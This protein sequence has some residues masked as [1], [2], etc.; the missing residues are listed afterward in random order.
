MSMATMRSAIG[1]RHRYL[2][3]Q[4]NEQSDLGAG[5]RGFVSRGIQQMVI[6]IIQTA[7]RQDFLLS[8]PLPSPV[9]LLARWGQLNFVR[10][11]S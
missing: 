8:I 3:T 6:K 9:G 5:K 10:R 2:F 1:F 11:A 7:S 4:A